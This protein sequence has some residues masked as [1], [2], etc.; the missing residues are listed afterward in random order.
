MA[1]V[2]AGRE[3][4]L[5]DTL[6][7]VGYRAWGTVIRFD[8]NAAVLRL[9]GADGAH[10]DVNVISGGVVG[11]VRQAYWHEP[12]VLDLPVQDVQS[13]QRTVNFIVQEF[14]L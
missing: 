5:G 2:I 3:V 1:V 10:R 11:S 4:K 13:I 6:Y 12:L 7:H 8:T 9:F 14:E